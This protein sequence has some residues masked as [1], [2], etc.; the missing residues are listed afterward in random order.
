ME[1]PNG[2]VTWADVVTG[3]VA[4]ERATF[5]WMPSQPMQGWPGNA[6]RLEVRSFRAGQVQAR[7]HSIATIYVEYLPRGARKLRSAIQGSSPSLVIVEGWNHPDP[8]AGWVPDGDRSA[9]S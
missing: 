5:Y 9:R 6:H 8:P 3:I 7:R 2:F 4:S 1:S